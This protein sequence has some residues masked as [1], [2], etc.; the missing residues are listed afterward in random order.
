MAGSIA[1][2]APAAPASRRA[3]GQVR[4]K[5]PRSGEDS[6]PVS[7]PASGYAVYPLGYAVHALEDDHAE[8]LR[9]D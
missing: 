3:A 9:P 4:P 6:S 7:G 2:A 1:E 5:S 8:C